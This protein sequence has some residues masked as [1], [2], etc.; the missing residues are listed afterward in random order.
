MARD[1]DDSKSEPTVDQPL[2]AK[3]RPRVVPVVPLV[4]FVAVVTLILLVEPELLSSRG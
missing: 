4:A 2:N 1:P 3:P